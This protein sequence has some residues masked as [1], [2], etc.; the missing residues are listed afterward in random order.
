MSVSA[1]A[2]IDDVFHKILNSHKG[3][4]TEISKFAKMQLIG[5]ML[6][7]IFPKPN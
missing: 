5:P 3:F 6:L 4:L 1:L 2:V 7:I